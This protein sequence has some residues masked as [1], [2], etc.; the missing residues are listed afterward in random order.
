V[1][2]ANIVQSIVSIDNTIVRWI[3]ICVSGNRRIRHTRVLSLNDVVQEQEYVHPDR[4]QSELYVFD[5]RGFHL[6][7]L[8]ALT[9]AVIVEFKYNDDMQLEA[10]VDGFNRTLQI[11]RR[12]DGRLEAFV[13]PTGE[14]STVTLTDDG[15]LQN[16]VE[17]SGV[18]ST[19][20][21]DSGGLITSHEPPNGCRQSYEYC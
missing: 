5:S 15:M 20:Q 2:H 10:V 16:M 12:A 3:D 7:T 13:A 9:K 21:Y 4:S 6:R 11:Q 14:R 8:D 17:P 19:F 18:Q 1:T